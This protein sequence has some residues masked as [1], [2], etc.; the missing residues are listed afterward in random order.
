MYR[1]P[2]SYDAMPIAKSEYPWKNKLTAFYNW[3]ITPIE[4][5]H[6]YDITN[7]PNKQTRS[8]RRKMEIVSWRKITECSEAV[9]SCSYHCS[10]PSVTN[11]QGDYFHNNIKTN[12]KRWPKGTMR[13]WRIHIFFQILRKPWYKQMNSRLVCIGSLQITW[14][15][16]P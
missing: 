6:H 14:E 12:P 4:K 16:C 3:K 8:S 7:Q 10:V 15:N 11:I 1:L 13:N 5:Y 9:Y 2:A